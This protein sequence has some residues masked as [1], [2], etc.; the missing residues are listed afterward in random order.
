MSGNT[1]GLFPQDGSEKTRE[2]TPREVGLSGARG[3]S[4]SGTGAV[5]ALGS[6][7]G[8]PPGAG[9]VDL[10]A[11]DL[12]ARAF[13]ILADERERW[14]SARSVNLRPGSSS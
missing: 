2:G 8:D 12:V 4:R 9:V 7:R 5:R 10:Q 11:D 14:R 6:T 3:L 1:S 13:A